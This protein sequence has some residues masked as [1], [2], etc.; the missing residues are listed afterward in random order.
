MGYYLNI[1][2]SNYLEDYWPCAGGFFENNSTGMPDSTMAV[3]GM[4]GRHGG[5]REKGDEP[6]NRHRIQPGCGDCGR[7]DWGR[8]NRTR[9]ATPNSQARTGTGK[10]EI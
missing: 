8:D 1:C 5:K 3:G 2:N 6:V 4:D 7:A 9:L 10:I